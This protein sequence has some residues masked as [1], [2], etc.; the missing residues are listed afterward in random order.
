MIVDTFDSGFF[1][2]LGTLVFG[3]I[4]LCVRTCFKSKCDNVDYSCLWDCFKLKIHRNVLLEEHLE[5]LVG[6]SSSLKS[7]DGEKV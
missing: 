2:T 5:H 3:S 6:I 1:L 7:D 4:A